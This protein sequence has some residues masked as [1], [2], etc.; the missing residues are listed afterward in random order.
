MHCGTP[1]FG[2]GLPGVSQDNHQHWRAVSGL[3]A[4]GTAP[5]GVAG[6]F[7][8]IRRAAGAATAVYFGRFYLIA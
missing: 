3:F 6:R 4:P 1:T 2:R 5:I 7:L 8:T